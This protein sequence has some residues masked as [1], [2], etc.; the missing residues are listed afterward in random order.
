MYLHQLK[1]S[2]GKKVILLI[3]IIKPNNLQ[4]HT[5]LVVF[6]VDPFTAKQHKVTAC[7]LYPDSILRDKAGW[8][9][10]PRNIPCETRLSVQ[11]I[12]PHHDSY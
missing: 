4:Q 12:S 10:E 5:S 1:T 3:I 2:S 7:L 6:S 8:E 11:W 9:P